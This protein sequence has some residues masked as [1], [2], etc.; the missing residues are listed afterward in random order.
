MILSNLTILW[1]FNFNN[2]LHTI[3]MSRDVT[4]YKYIQWFWCHPKENCGCKQNSKS[5]WLLYE[6]SLYHT[7]MQFSHHNYQSLMVP[8]VNQQTAGWCNKALSD[9]TQ[10]Q[11]ALSGGDPKWGDDRGMLTCP[12]IMAL[13]TALRVVIMISCN[14]TSHKTNLLK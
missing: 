2:Q 7:S 3:S 1:S 11:T 6:S 4:E 9:I 8:G 5:Q 13:R 14:A 12:K 10:S